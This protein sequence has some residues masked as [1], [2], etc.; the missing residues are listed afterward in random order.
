[1]E[2]KAQPGADISAE[3]IEAIRSFPIEREI[4]HC[5]IKQRVNPFDIY[6][7]C[8]QCGSQIKLRS[9]SAHFEIED[10]FDAVFE[11]MLQPGTAA[12]VGQRQQAIAADKE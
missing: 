10:I 9:F 7:T 5:G 3:L 6:L 1:M 2:L 12:L 4:E 11:W 8:S